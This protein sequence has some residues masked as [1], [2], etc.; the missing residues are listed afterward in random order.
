M[1]RNRLLTIALASAGLVTLAGATHN[2]RVGDDATPF[3]DPV[4]SERRGFCLPNGADG[5]VLL[6]YYQRL[7]KTELGPFPTR[8]DAAADTPYAQAEPPLF[9]NLG[10]VGMKISTANPK[11]QSYFDQGLRLA[12][13]FN[14]AEARRAFRM[15]QRLDPDCAMCW[16]GE[17]LVLGPNINAPM[18]PE[19]N[20]P[21]LY[22]VTEAQEAAHRGTAKEQDLI[23]ALGKR[24]SADPKADRH[25]LDTAYAGAMAAVAGRYPDDDNI[26]ALY[27]ESLM[28]LQPWDYWEKAGAVPKGNTR[29]ILATLER[30]LARNPDHPGAIHFYIHMTEASS[31][32]ARA[33]PYARRLAAA[34]PGAGHLVH[35]PFHTLFRIGEYKDA[36]AANVAAVAA[37]EAYIRQASPDG[38]Y[39][40][41]YYP[42][43]VHSLMISAQMA[44][45]GRSA[46]EAADKL[47]GVVSEEA[48]LKVPWVQPIVVAPYFAHAQ[49]SR[50]DVILGL[51]DPGEGLPYVKAMWHYARGVAF[52]AMR[53][54]ESAQAEAQA[55]E[56]IHSTADFSGLI[57]GGVP[58]PDVL[59]LARHVVLA[60]VA[61]ARQDHAAARAA[62]EAA[63]EIE[64]RLAYSEPPFWYYPVRQSL[65][66][67]LLQ[68]GRAEE[69][70]Q[71]FRASL[72]RAPNNGWALWG[73]SQAHA[74]QG[75]TH[76]A[77]AVKKLFEQAW[78]GE[79]SGPDLSRL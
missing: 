28:D 42:H 31:S 8:I 19:A 52:A 29:E 41:A 51:N 38:I 61:Q 72:A 78:A 58:A 26:Q 14:H 18:E 6:R 32:P 16:W 49:F 57:A 30:V 60:R 45:D 48:A 70:E 21:A 24:Y 79:P 68:M 73:M 10:T 39:P 76:D 22:A 5:R 47:S 4:L 55:I 3:F 71:V 44:G 77:A 69:A 25:A 56:R 9:D 66:A 54:P 50:P 62:F 43:N 53:R 74:G 34:M 13:G 64:D 36:L 37:D 75:K 67:L 23:A 59:E 40:A 65:G 12:Y 35:M 7:A 1:K 11:A 20:A 27:A 33:E 15:A 17:A 63:I 46:L 2:D